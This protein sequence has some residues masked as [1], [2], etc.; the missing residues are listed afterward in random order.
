MKDQRMRPKVKTVPDLS[1]T[2]SAHQEAI[3]KGEDHFWLSYRNVID[4][5]KGLPTEEI[6]SVLRRTALPF[7]VCFENF[8]G[9]FNLAT[10]ARNANAF[11]ASEIFYVGNKKI[12]RRGMMGIQNY[13]DIQH[14]S[15]IDDLL[16]LKDRYV[17]I[18]I[19]NVPGSVPM[20]DYVYPRNAM[21]IFGEEGTG[22][23]PMMQSYCKDVV[24]IPQYGSVRSL[25]C[26]TA[27]G[28]AMNDYC[29]KMRRL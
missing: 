2:S 21:L 9:D 3:A 8:L 1:A 6:R 7:A 24:F 19:D 10:G 13:H 14:L 23:T 16:K 27:S 25:N 12:D 29:M 4:E 15:T 5:F 11:N 20:Y 26:G 18:G 17:F 28:I 22:L